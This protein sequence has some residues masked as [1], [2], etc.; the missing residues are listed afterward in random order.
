MTQAWSVSFSNPKGDAT[1]NDLELGAILIQ[2][3][4]FAPRMAP[5]AHIRTYVDD[6]AAQV[7]AN[8]ASVS[9][10]PAVG[11]ILHDLVMAARCQHIH[12][13]VG[14][15]P[16][17]DNEMADATS[18]LTHIPVRLFLSHLKM[19]FSQSKYWC[20]LPLP[21]ARRKQ[22]TTM[23]HSKRSTKVFLQRSSKRRPPPGANG[24]AYAAGYTSPPIS[25]ASNTPSLYFIFL[26]SAYVPTFCLQQVTPTR[27]DCLINTSASS[28]PSSRHWGPTTHDTTEWKN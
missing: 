11:P 25:K 27:N 12:T 6:T 18:R 9:I 19:H 13:S 3:L 15:V 8:R 26:K 7:W 10:A 22:L 17:E 16:R 1:I 21:P 4:V 23:L 2:I 14:C 5:L 20:V 28:A 24:G